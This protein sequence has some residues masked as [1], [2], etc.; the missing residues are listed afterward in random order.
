[1]KCSECHTKFKGNVCPNC[2]ATPTKKGN[3]I[4]PLLILFP[5]LFGLAFGV[6]Q[7]V[8][9]P[10]KYDSSRIANKYI[11]ATV[12][13]GKA[14]DI[15]LN[16]CGITEVKTFEHDELLDNAHSEG[17]T[18][19]RLSLNGDIDNIILYLNADKTVHSLKYSIYTLYSD[20][21]IL[22]TLQDYTFTTNELT[23]LQIECENKVKE[24]LQSPSSAAFPNILEWGFLK[25]KNIVTIQGYV[26]ALN[27][28]GVEIRS[29]FQFII[30]TDTNTILS[31]I[32]DG[33]ELVEQ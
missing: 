9:H 24:I 15:I 21:T 13:E 30:D 1:M 19:Y 31:F 25:E 20:N 26:D 18:G 22:A 32:F 4:I 3:R 11:D 33:Q 6:N 10:E 2:G 8:Q 23:N 14:I 16:D 27:G 29:E 28:F 12:E 17:E 7:M 5:F